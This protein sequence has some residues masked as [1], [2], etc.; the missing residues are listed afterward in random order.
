M[1]SIISRGF[2]ASSNDNILFVTEQCNNRCIMCCQPPKDND[3]IDELFEQN[4]QKILGA[5]KNINYIGI[6]GGEPTLLGDKLPTLISLIREKL[7][8]THIHI[9]SNGRLFSSPEYA[10]NVV[11]V[12]DWMISF[13]IP[14]HSD[15]ENDHNLIAGN[16]RAYQETL[17]GLYNLAMNSSAIELRI[18]INN[19]NYKRLPQISQF[20]LKNLSF[21]SWISFIGM[22]R[23]GNADTLDKHIWVEPK[24]YIP[25]LTEA[26]QNLSMAGYDVRIYNIP[27]CLLP[28]TAHIFAFQS[29]SE[30]KKYFLKECGPCLM[31]EKCC[32]LFATSS[33]PF[34]GINPILHQ[35]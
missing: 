27:L 11:S 29:I 18:V 25:Y 23:I 13:G 8:D 35:E 26:C 21:V 4:I 32:G 16:N 22:E 14:L 33:K 2:D 34:C 7:P 19:M 31:R 20:I 5:P 24:L 28:P 3:D 9:L 17:Y 30:W 10:S 6:T 12:G 15:Y 1:D